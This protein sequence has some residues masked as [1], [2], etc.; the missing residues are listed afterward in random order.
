MKQ[1]KPYWANNP[2]PI[3]KNGVR[4]KTGL[5]FEL[6]GRPD[7]QTIISK[8]EVINLTIALNTT[9]DVNDFLKII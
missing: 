9:E 4:V 7:R 8:D 5:T 3:F 1:E 6:T 2:D